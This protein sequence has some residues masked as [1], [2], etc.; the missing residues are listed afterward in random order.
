M[1]PAVWENIAISHACKEGHY[2][3]VKLLLA[4]PR[5][6]P[7]A[8][9]NRAIKGAS[10][11]GHDL[12]VKLLLADPTINPA[13]QDNY[14]IR[15]ASLKGHNLLWSC[16]LLTFKSKSRGRRKSSDRIGKPG[17]SRFSCKATAG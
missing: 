11:K 7:A 16:C 4:D 17:R 9:N 14:A 8:D 6:N 12:V 15:F 10:L 3:V 2:S 13:A 1:D 5:V